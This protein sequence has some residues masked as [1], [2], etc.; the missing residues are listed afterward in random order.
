MSN[1]MEIE[2]SKAPRQKLKRHHS[3]LL[4]IDIEAFSTPVKST[5]KV[6]LNSC[7][8]L[9]NTEKSYAYLLFKTGES[10]EKEISSKLKR[11]QRTVK[12]FLSKVSSQKSFDPNHKSKGRWKKGGG[13][14]DSRHKAMLRNWINQGVLQSAKD[15]W[16][17]LNKIK[18]LPFISYKPVNNYL[19]TLGAFVKPRLKSEVSEENKAE[20]VRFCTKF[21]K[22]NFKRVLFCDESLFELNRNNQKVF[23]LKGSPPPTKIKYNPNSR[24]MVWGG[25][26][27]W[28]KT[29]IHFVEGTMKGKDYK[30]LLQARRRDILDIFRE[31]GKWYFLHDGAPCHRPQTVKRYIRRWLTPNIMPHPAQSLDLN[32]IELVWALMKK[33]S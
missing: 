27:F 28:G 4:M 32:P 11:D 2:T 30:E 26:S 24:V 19:K 22:F 33:K 9:S 8:L 25:V 21:K 29:S 17:R 10:N 15:G 23:R 13:K 6:K 7:N 20:R 31:K 12:S 18:N 3:D 14:L 1:T 16:R 5:K